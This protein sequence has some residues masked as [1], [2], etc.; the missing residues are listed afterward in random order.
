MMND[1][2][3]SFYAIPN[4]DERLFTKNGT[5]F[6]AIPNHDERLAEPIQTR[7]HK[8]RNAFLHHSEP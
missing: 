4:H 5:P 7:V 2:Q 8:K 1:W 3:N 6:Y